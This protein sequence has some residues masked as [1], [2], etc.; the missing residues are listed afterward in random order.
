MASSNGG[1]PMTRSVDVFFD[2]HLNK[3]LANNRDA[4]D[5]RCHRAHLN[6]TQIDCDFRRRDAHVAAPYRGHV[7]VLTTLVQELYA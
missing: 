5:F 7:L 4:S 2:L 3:R 1:R 6:I